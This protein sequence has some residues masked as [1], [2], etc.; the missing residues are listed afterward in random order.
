MGTHPYS[1]N[2]YSYVVTELARQMA[3]F[4]D[5]S[6]TVF[7]FQNFGNV[8]EEHK[9]NR[10]I[11]S[12]V[13]VYDAYGNEKEHTTMGFGFNEVVE[14]VTLNKPDLIVIYNDAVVVSNILDKLKTIPN[15]TFK[16]A[17][18]V[19]QVYLNQKKEYIKR[20]NEETDMAIAFTPYWEE[21]LKEQGIK[22]PTDYLCHGFNKMAHYP[23]PKKLARQ[24]F[25][26]GEKDFIIT[27]MNRNT[28]RKRLDLCMRAFALVVSRHLEDPIKY[29]IGTAPQGAFN[30]LEIYERELQKYGISMEEGMKHIILIDR[31]QQ[32][33]DDEMNILLNVADVGINTA[34]GEGFG[35]IALQQSGIGVPQIA[36]NVGGHKDYLTPD[37]SILIEPAITMYQSNTVDGVGGEAEIC[38]WKDFAEA[39]ERYYADEELRKNHGEAGRKLVLKKYPWEVIGE[40]FHKIIR[41][42]HPL[43]VEEVQT[44]NH[45]DIAFN[46]AEKISLKD[47]E[48]LEDNVNI[49]DLK[50]AVEAIETAEAPKETPAAPAP[51][52][53]RKKKDAP[54][55]AA[56][57]TG[58]SAT[59]ERLRSKLEEKKQAAKAAGTTE[60]ASLLAGASSV[61]ELMALKQKIDALLKQSGKV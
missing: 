11:P 2:G 19:D 14:F 48:K 56:A 8:P 23:V 41:K 45:G 9:R 16:I 54:P 44:P 28:D 36:S 24:Y 55:A 21:K 39:I 46:S 31:P 30:L 15:R 22:I 37:T 52:R 40:H 51:K 35:L 50:K 47:L 34:I 29:L 13:Y 10:E 59:R 17:I 33:S 58:A 18:Y 1:T 3:K 7:G 25:G 5:V 38:D 4:S 57:P 60:D 6:F 53:G 61:E 32:L 27:N 26:L 49:N 43:A 42:I 12:S 20:L